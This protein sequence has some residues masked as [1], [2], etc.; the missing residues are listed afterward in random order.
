ME[1][2]YAVATRSLFHGV[3]KMEKTKLFIVIILVFAFGMT[4]GLMTGVSVFNKKS[5]I[6]AKTAEQETKVCWDQARKRLKETGFIPDSENQAE[7]KSI[8]G[9]ITNI[10]GS[11][12]ALKTRPL[13]VLSDP[14]L[15]NRTIEIG[16]ATKYIKWK[17]LKGEAE[18]LL[19]PVKIR[20]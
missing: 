17:K 15:D 11:S 18:R 20:V 19:A 5:K 2:R 13:E 16:E 1:Y 12:I 7:T 6:P 8:S 10:S 9:E 14:S 4:I 3:K